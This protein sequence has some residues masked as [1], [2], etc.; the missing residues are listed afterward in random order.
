[1]NKINGLL[2]REAIVSD[3]L[4]LKEFEQSLIEY[5]RP[6]APNLKEGFISYYDIQKF[7]E[8]PDSFL[9]VGLLNG[10]IVSSGYAQIRKSASYKTPEQFVYLGFMY[11]N[12]I[13]RGKGINGELI[14]ELIAWAHNKDIHEIQLD[15]YAENKSALNAYEKLGFKPDLLKMRL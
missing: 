12:P 14:K 6:F 7:I 3:L 11:V 13:H 5:E 15:V 2:L 10:E 1:M 9:L 8:D 4:I